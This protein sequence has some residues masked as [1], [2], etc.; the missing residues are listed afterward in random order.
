MKTNKKIILLTLGAIIVILGA[1]FIAWLRAPEEYPGQADSVVV[2]SPQLEASAL[3][4]I[5]ENQHFFSRNGL[6]VTFHEPDSGLAS[7]NELLEGEADIAGTAEYPVV[8]KV[9]KKER[10]HIIGC[11]DKLDYT[12]LV[13]RKDKGIEKV[14]DLKGKR[15]GTKPGTSTDFYLGR[16]L[17]LNGMNMQD[18]TLVDVKTSAE[19]VNAII[20]GSIDAVVVSEPFASSVKDSLGA[21]AVV[22]RVQSSQPVYGLMVSNEEWIKRHPELVTRFL[23]SLAQAQDFTINHPAEAKAIVQKRLNVDGDYMDTIWRQNQYTLSLDQSLILA[24]EDEARWMINNN[25]TTE[26]NVPDFL[27]YINEDGLNEVKPEAVNIIR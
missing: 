21:N 2:A 22:W 1:A 12:F 26:K 24:M 25:L 10:I 17:K 14:S 9:F 5:A 15:I 4:W 8:E 13:G 16:F 20:N 7:L 23:K 6:N 3:L 11:I 18:I 27:G 19:S